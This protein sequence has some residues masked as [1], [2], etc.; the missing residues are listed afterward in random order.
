MGT[1]P[2]ERARSRG[3]V[4]LLRR[5]RLGLVVL[6]VAWFFSPPEIRDSVPLWLPF[7]V[8]L[9]LEVQFVAANYRSTAPFFRRGDRRPS[10]DDVRRYG[11]GTQADWAIVDVEGEPVWVDLA[12]PDEEPERAPAPTPAAVA[13]ARSRLRRLLR[14]A[15]EAA[16]V[17]AV[18]A[19]LVVLLD[20]GSWDD[21]GAAERR[22]AE[23]RISAEASA[24]AGKPV[25][26][27]CDTSGR[28]VGAVQHADG[29]AVVGGDRAYL[30][31]SLCYALH[32]LAAD[33]EVPSFSE[34]ARA[35]AVLAHEAWHLRGERDEG[36]TECF[37]VQSG[38]S[39]GRRLGLDEDT[40]R[41]MMR[42]QLVA[43]QLHRRGSA[44]YVVPAGCV[45][46]GPLDLRPAVDL[47]P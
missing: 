41:R 15:L 20:R 42:S 4:R 8:A 36:V 31:P 43:N 26:V 28:R 24:V 33:G 16:A 39:V 46:R 3:A 17:L 10:G 27:G 44:E 18:V 29:V 9:V 22:A 38:V 47:F 35:I 19:G 40:A 11:A 12:E 23:A 2:A 21:L 34:T 14:P 13:P 37:A 7:A 5:L 6:L 32:R 45:N 30:T 1:T 25:R